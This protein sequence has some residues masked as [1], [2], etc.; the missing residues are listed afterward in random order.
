M[1]VTADTGVIRTILGRPRSFEVG[2]RRFSFTPPS[3]GVTHLVSQ[4]LSRLGI[5]ARLLAV[6]PGAEVLRLCM[7]KKD[8]V[9][10]LLSYATMG[11]QVPPDWDGV[12]ERAEYFGRELS[13]EDMAQLLLLSLERDDTAAVMHSSGIEEERRW[14]ARVVR[15]KGDGSSLSFGGRTVYGALLDVACERYGWMLDY[16]VWG[17]SLANLQLLLADSVTSVYLTDKERKRIHVPGDRNVI[18]ADDPANFAMIRA[19][20]RSGDI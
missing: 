6:S 2:D 13:G 20:R 1:A 5:T 19:M 15:E 4:A 14:L 3:F 9:C 16:A 12:A 11:L 10:S 8:E 17:I 7:E 18:R